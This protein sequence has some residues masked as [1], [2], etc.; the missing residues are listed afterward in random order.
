M[1]MERRMRTRKL[2]T[3]TVATTGPTQVNTHYVPIR[4]LPM[5]DTPDATQARLLPRRRQRLPLPLKMT[6]AMLQQPTAMRRNSTKKTRPMTNQKKSL[7]RT[8]AAMMR[9]TPRTTMAALM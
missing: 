3:R 8:P 1:T 5:A 9:T 6:R 2:K 4:R 7:T